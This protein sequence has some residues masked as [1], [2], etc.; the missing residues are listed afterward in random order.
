MSLV[1]RTARVTLAPFAIIALVAC[2]QVPE[3]GSAERVEGG[4]VSV[5]VPG[6][7]TSDSVAGRGLVIAE[8]RHDLDVDVPA[9]PRVVIARGGDLPD[10][11]ELLTSIENAPG[12]L[13]GEPKELEVGGMP[14]VE[15]GQIAKHDR[16]N[17]EA[18]HIATV[19][20]SGESYLVRLEAPDDEWDLNQ[21][22]LDRIV[23]S[24]E[25]V[26]DGD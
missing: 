19:S 12:P 21:D 7:W 18:R 5:E 1:R 8:R 23:A 14:A 22:T 20:P 13:Q 9:G 4:G 10:P 16:V 2:Q 25:F 26:A 11:E 17:V 15:L 6:T 3:P 24:I